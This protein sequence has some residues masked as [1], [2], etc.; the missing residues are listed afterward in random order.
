MPRGKPA[1]DAYLEAARRLGVAP[2]RCLAVDDAEDGIATT[3]AAGM[4]TLTL[5]R[6]RLILAS[7]A[8]TS[9]AARAT[10]P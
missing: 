5:Y 10:Q 2:A 8:T 4:R 1:P 3:I 7:T 6:G 9:G